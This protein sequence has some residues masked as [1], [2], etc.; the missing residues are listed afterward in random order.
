VE[1]RILVQVR[2]Q[3]LINAKNGAIRHH[4]KLKDVSEKE[5]I[6]GLQ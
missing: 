6:E 4:K 5:K 2:A 1:Q 3:R